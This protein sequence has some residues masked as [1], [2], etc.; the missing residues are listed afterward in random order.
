MQNQHCWL[1]LPS[2][3]CPQNVLVYTYCVH[4]QS[5]LEI[6]CTI[7]CVFLSPRIVM[8]C[9]HIWVSF[10]SLF[11]FFTQEIELVF[12]PH[13]KDHDP[14]TVAQQTRYI[15]TT[16]NASGELTCGQL[17]CTHIPQLNPPEN[18]SIVSDSTANVPLCSCRSIYVLWRHS[19]ACF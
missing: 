13:P 1:F 18:V 12:K 7:T 5:D 17:P 15:K 14:E 6:W 16:A 10:F 11:Y 4:G 8:N 9:C 3:N 19:I 2:S